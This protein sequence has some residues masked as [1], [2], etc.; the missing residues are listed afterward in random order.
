MSKGFKHMLQTVDGW[1]W[2]LLQI[3]SEGHVELF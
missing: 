2:H 3:F 1:L